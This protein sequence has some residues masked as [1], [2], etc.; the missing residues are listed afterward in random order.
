MNN[1]TMIT[2]IHQNMLSTRGEADSQ[3]LLV[4]VTCTLSVTGQTLTISQT[5]TRSANS[6]TRGFSILYLYPARMG[7]LHPH[8]QASSLGAMN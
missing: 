8:L 7:N 3:D 2:D 1:H 6:T 5:Q 4:S